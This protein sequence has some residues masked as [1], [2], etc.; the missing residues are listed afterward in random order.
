MSKIKT[1]K[2]NTG[3]LLILQLSNYILPLLLI[4]YLTH[5]LGISLYGIIAFGISIVQISCIITDFGF[6]L[7][8][9]YQIAKHQSNRE[10]VNRIITSVFLCKALICMCVII[11]LC[12]FINLNTKY[13]EYSTYFYLLALPIVGQTIQPLWLFQGIEQMGYVTIYSII[14]RSSFLILTVLLVNQPSEYFWVAVSN[15]ASQIAA[16]LI[17]IYLMLKLGYRFSLPRPKQLSRTFFESLE[18]FW[19]RAAVAIY[20]AGGAFFLGITSTPQQVAIYSAAE[21]LYKAAQALFQP[22]AQSLYP[23]MAKNRDIALFKK[24][25]KTITFT[26]I[27]GFIIGSIFGEPIIQWIFGKSFSASYPVLLVFM[28]TY[29]IT[30]PSI[31]LGYPFLGALGD[32]KS[33]NYSVIYAG[34]LQILLLIT[35]C[36]TNQKEALYVAVTVLLSEVLVLSYRFKKSLKLLKNSPSKK[37]TI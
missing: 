23:Y 10:E 18:F 14:A 26:S 4:P 29:C 33:A 22:V 11:A 5:T 17:S 20:T 3:A 24:I 37:C 27:L 31:L 19:S 7:S 30:M 35:L 21:Q 6:N 32:S 36:I 13:K 34:L 12:I 9:T 8:A 2:K 1:L 16:A 28:L 15:G 25:L